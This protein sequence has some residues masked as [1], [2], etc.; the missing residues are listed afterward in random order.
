MSNVI[1][2]S[3]GFAKKSVRLQNKKKFKF[4]LHYS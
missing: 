3:M 1:I 2:E 4:E